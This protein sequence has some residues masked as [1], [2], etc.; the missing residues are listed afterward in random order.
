MSRFGI[1]SGAPNAQLSE[2][3]VGD[4]ANGMPS[5]R[6][7]VLFRTL[8][9]QFLWI[10]PLTIIGSILI[11]LAT[12]GIK[13]T[14][15]GEGQIMVQL[16]AEYVYQSVDGAAQTQNL[17]LT[18]DIISLN[19][20]A[21][22]KNSAVINQV[23]GE[24]KSHPNFAPKEFQ[25][26]EMASNEMELK[27]AQLK[28]YQTVENS[29]LV[30]PR[31]KSSVIDVAYKHEDGEV[32]VQTLEKLILAYIDHR[33]TIFVEGSGD[34]ISGQRATTEDQLQLTE[35]AIQAFL[36]KN[37][38]SNFESES[39]G[40]TERTEKMR[41][42][43]NLLRA[44]LVESE[45]ALATVEAQLRQTPSEINLYVD[46]RAAQRVAQAE[47]E[48]KQLLA[49]YLPSSDPVRTKQAEIDQLKSL[50]DANSGK[51]VGGRRVGPNTVHQALMTRR[52]MLQST[53]D[54]QREKEFALSQQL[55]AVDSKVK[56]LQRL[57]PQYQSL[58]RER[59]T[60]DIR[61]KGYTN[62][63]QE[64]LINQQ[65]QATESENVRVIAWPELPRKGRNMGKIYWALGT[66]GWAFTLFMMALIKV[67]LDPKLYADP[68]ARMRGQSQ[69]YNTTPEPAMA[70]YAVPSGYTPDTHI[71]EPVPAPT[72]PE[73]YN[74]TS[75][76]VATYD[77]Y[78]SNPYAPQ[79]VQAYA[80]GSTAHDIYA[81]PYDQSG[82]NPA[83]VPVLGTV[84][85]SETS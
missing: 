12:S 85:S 64:A 84:P 28:L 18:P 81:N 54:A 80:D 68:A 74:P 51:A 36:R 1:N 14:Y 2:M 56:K 37:G 21:L 6:L 76:E 47:L 43:L 57:L 78:Q 3:T 35:T 48:M 83:A 23:I 66:V 34:I 20:V 41:A 10:I 44:Q 5:I 77:N 61:L 25:K 16:G 32:A 71:P 8:L 52:N 13:R 17:L 49:K 50:Q 29:F 40:A 30:A 72:Y 79:P 58:I 65:K 19:E 63:E 62:K 82:Y 73:R 22:M 24:M 59:D 33:K 75:P 70:S 27:E 9:K 67:F 11:F 60:L 55:R 42:D 31:P 39:K 46:D 53:A 15:K 38:I 26:I 4:Y 45:T 69:T 7:G